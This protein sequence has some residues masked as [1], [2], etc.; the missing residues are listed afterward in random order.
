VWILTGMGIAIT[1]LVYVGY[2]LHAF[3][4]YTESFAPGTEIMGIGYTCG[5]GYASIPSIWLGG[6]C[7]LIGGTLSLKQ[8]RWSLAVF[9][10]IAFVAAWL[11]W[12][13]G[14]WG[15]Q[16]IMSLRKLIPHQ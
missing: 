13:V 1:A 9:A 8:K 11:P 15:F 3:Y 12:F 16:Y 7:A 14:I 4:R 6:A 10:G 5:L 2:I